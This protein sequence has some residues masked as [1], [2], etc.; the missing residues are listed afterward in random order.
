VDAFGQFGFRDALEFA[1]ELDVL[2]DFHFGVKRRG[3]R[4]VTDAAFDFHGLF[5]DV[6]TGDL[7]TAA[8]RGEE[9]GEN[10][11]RSG[12]AGSVRAK[13]TNDLAFLDLEGDVIHGNVA[14]VPFSE[15]FYF[16]HS[17]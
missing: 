13:K 2:D 1:Y 10:A 4:Q 11:H 9:A 8:R 17:E 5:L 3:F 16:D 7:G 14:R 6:E 12:F 15:A